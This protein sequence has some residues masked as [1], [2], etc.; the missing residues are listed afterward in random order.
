[1]KSGVFMAKRTIN[2]RQRLRRS[3]WVGWLFLN[4]NS[5]FGMPKPD[6]PPLV[7]K[8]IGAN[9][10]ERK[11]LDDFIRFWISQPK[12][13]SPREVFEAEGFIFIEGREKES[14]LR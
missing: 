5:S 13:M 2:I 14:L 6:C 12:P 10:P 8:A 11:T 1:M 9:E 3:I 7:L 4:V